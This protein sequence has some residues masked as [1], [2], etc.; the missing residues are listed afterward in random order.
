MDYAVMM[1]FEEDADQTISKWVDDLC[2]LGLNDRFKQINMRPHLTLAEFDVADISAVESVLAE[3][4]RSQVH[5]DLKFS[6]IGIFPGET[7]VMF[8]SPIISDALLDMHRQLNHKL[9][10]CCDQFSPLYR[11]E[12]WVAHCTLA[13]DYTEAEVASA[14]HYLAKNFHPIETR[15][16]SLVLFGCCPYHEMMVFPFAAQPDQAVI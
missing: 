10:H 13:L 4:S 5:L 12:N 11:E 6:S 8:L 3:F 7:G 2:A 15:A 14:Y 1:Y 9:E 16:V